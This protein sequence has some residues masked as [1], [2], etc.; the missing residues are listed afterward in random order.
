MNTKIKLSKSGM[1]RLGKDIAKQIARENS[2]R[3]FFCHRP[4]QPSPSMPEDS[5]PVCDNC[6]KEHGLVKD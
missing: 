6:A 1:S 3:C 2:G 5:V 4:V